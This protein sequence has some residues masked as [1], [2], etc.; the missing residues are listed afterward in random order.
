M[1][2]G[3]YRQQKCVNAIHPSCASLPGS[4]LLSSIYIP[5]SPVAYGRATAAPRPSVVPP[6]VPVVS[7]P[8]I[9]WWS[10]LSTPASVLASVTWY[11]RVYIGTGA[12]SGSGRRPRT[13]RP[14]VPIVIVRRQSRRWWASLSLPHRPSIISI[15]ATVHSVPAVVAIAAVEAGCGPIGIW[16][17]AHGSTPGSRWKSGFAIVELSAIKL[18]T[19]FEYRNLVRLDGQRLHLEVRVFQSVDCVYPRPPVKLEQF[20][21]ERDGAGAKPDKFSLA[22]LMCQRLRICAQPYSL[23]RVDRLPDRVRGDR[24]SPPGSFFHPGIVSSLGV[25]IRSQ[26]ISS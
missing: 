26:I 1:S 24:W 25:P 14:A 13:R 4:A 19:L 18:V 22:N 8:V 20:F 11:V 21:E 16:P 9:A 15:S 10:V 7:R 3:L 12:S 23:K 6:V 17:K 2:E 5:V